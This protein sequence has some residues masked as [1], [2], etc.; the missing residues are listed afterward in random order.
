[1]LSKLLYLHDI[2]YNVIGQDPSHDT[3][4]NITKMQ[5]SLHLTTMLGNASLSSWISDKLLKREE[6][7]VE[8]DEIDLIFCLLHILFKVS[9]CGYAKIMGAYRVKNKDEKIQKMIVLGAEL[10]ITY[11]IWSL[12]MNKIWQNLLFSLITITMSIK[13][14]MKIGRIWL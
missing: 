8:V 3:L 4:F 14:G 12:I 5:Y 13:D 10:I 7:R 2:Y 9:P 6:E 11:S 1:L